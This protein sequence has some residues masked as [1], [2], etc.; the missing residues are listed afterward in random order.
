MRIFEYSKW[1]GTQH[2]PPP[3]PQ[4]LFDTL[5]EYVLNYGERMLDRL[6]ELEPEQQELLEQLIKEGYIERDRRGRYRV[7]PKGVRRSE[8]KALQDLFQSMARSAAGKHETPQRGPGQV[9]H[10]DSRP[11][12]YGDPL[13]N[14]N[15]QETLKNAVMRQGGGLPIRIEPEDLVVYDTEFQTACAT[16]LLVDMSGS[17][18][19]YGKY[20]QAKKVALALH[21][22]VRGRYPEDTLR[23]VGF[24]SYASPL[25]ERTLMSSSPKPVSIFDDHVFLRVPLDD[26]PPFV[27]E[28]FTNIQAGLRYARHILAKS[29]VQNRQIIIITDGEP[30]AHIEGRELLLVYP[31]SERTARHTLAEAV[32]CTERGIRIS[33]FALVE[34][35]F[36]LALSNFVEKLARVA[37]GVAVYC[38]AGELG[39]YVLEDFQ[40][41]R[42]ARRTIG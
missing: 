11:Y 24:Y 7:S 33:V 40:S 8:E 29:P 15:L 18:G 32:R 22:L 38:S 34:D 37:R 16:V 41:G 9:K 19:R 17:M 30:T 4:S 21:A 36:Y 42:R 20:Y 26:P 3:L 28:H 14:L 12:Q 31:P 25:D 39:K 35:Y 2:F 10:E 13:D 1:D 5:A 23:V 27:P 6:K